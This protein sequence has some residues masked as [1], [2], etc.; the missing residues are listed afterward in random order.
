MPLPVANSRAIRLARNWQD[1][2]AGDMFSIMRKPHFISVCVLVLLLLLGVNPVVPSL[3]NPAVTGQQAPAVVMSVAATGS[4]CGV[5]GTVDDI[6]MPMGSC[7]GICSNLPASSETALLPEIHAGASFRLEAY[8]VGDG[9]S[10]GPEPHPPR[11][12]LDI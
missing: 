3:A 12:H 4:G 6:G 9:I 11:S 2:W 8:G 10:G 1:P 5:C 7:A